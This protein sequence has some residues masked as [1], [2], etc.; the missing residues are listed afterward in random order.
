LRVGLAKG[1]SKE[2]AFLG[3]ARM[4]NA[5]P[6]T[7]MLM[8]W[9][10]V[11]TLGRWLIWR[12]V[13]FKRWLMRCWTMMGEMGSRL[14]MMFMGGICQLVKE[15]RM[16]EVWVHDWQEYLGRKAGGRVLEDHW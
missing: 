15:A 12:T 16:E 3:A 6:R 2:N 5:K 13:G 14:G 4:G 1:K 9:E 8:R 11:W 7:R 10:K